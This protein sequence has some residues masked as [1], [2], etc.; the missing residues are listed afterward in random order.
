MRFSIISGLILFVNTV[1]LAEE[2]PTLSIGSKAPAFSL[3]GVDGKTYSLAS[4]TK[5]KIVVIIFTCNH[6]PTAQAYE[7]RIIQL[8]KDYNPKGVA[9]VAVSPNDPRSIRLDE[10]GYTDMSDTYG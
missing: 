10:L 7:E 2:H 5:Y 3:K 9:I 6:C 1:L 4:F 8:A